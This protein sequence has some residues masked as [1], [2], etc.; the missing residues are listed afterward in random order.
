MLKSLEVEFL[1]GDSSAEMSEKEKK[2]FDQ[3]VD[4]W[5]SRLELW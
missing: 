2:V 3:D 4:K 5:K 1:F